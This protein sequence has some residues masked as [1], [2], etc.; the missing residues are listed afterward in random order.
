MKKT[1]KSGCLLDLINRIYGGSLSSA[2][3]SS[4]SSSAGDASLVISHAYYERFCYDS[5]FNDDGRGVRKMEA[6]S[7]PFL[8]VIPHILQPYNNISIQYIK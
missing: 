1:V 6:Q 8:V 5:P 4:C 7:H 3:S 2:S